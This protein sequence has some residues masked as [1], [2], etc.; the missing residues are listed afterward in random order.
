MKGNVDKRN[1]SKLA[2]N[3][4]ENIAYTSVVTLIMV[5]FS[6]HHLKYLFHYLKECN[7]VSF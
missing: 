1:Y 2:D 5:E 4:K 3:E 7:C 6:E